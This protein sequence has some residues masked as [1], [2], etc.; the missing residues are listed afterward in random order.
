MSKRK[1]F[2]VDEVI[3]QLFANEGVVQEIPSVPNMNDENI[4]IVVM[5]H[6]SGPTMDMKI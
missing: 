4:H 6:Q 3:E 5:N 1:I 2:S